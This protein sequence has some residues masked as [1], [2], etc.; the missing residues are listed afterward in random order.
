MRKWVDSLS[1][2]IVK[3]ATSK[4]GK[5]VRKVGKKVVAKWNK[6]VVEGYK[7]NRKAGLSV[8]GS[9]YLA[10]AQAKRRNAVGAFIAGPGSDIAVAGGAAVYA[11][12]KIKQKRRKK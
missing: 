2:G 10:K 9:R 3:A 11:G 6:P 7:K 12:A 8:E 1:K 5:A 4:P